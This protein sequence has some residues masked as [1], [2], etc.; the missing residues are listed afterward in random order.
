MKKSRG[1]AT[2][3][4]AVQL[5]PY[6]RVRRL[7]AAFAIANLLTFAQHRAENAYCHPE[8]SEGSA[9]ACA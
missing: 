8:R 5:F 1:G 3:A 6:F 7:A 2:L 4:S 9:F